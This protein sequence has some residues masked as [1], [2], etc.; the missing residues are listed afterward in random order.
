MKGS[1]HV[2]I[3]VPSTTFFWSDR[4][5]LG[6]HQ[7]SPVRKEFWGKFRRISNGYNIK[8]LFKAKYTFRNLL[9]RTKPEMRLLKT[10]S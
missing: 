5:K 4:G 3:R 2:V 1:D 7:S 9:T 10:A 6:S 8:P